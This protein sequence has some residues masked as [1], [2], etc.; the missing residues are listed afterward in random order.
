MINICQNLKKGQELVKT[1]NSLLHPVC[2]TAVSPHSLA[3]LKFLY[4]R[5]TKNVTANHSSRVLSDFKR[6][7][8]RPN[9]YSPSF[10]L[11]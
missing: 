6:E 2:H 7:W 3:L 9:R 1:V 8:I 4:Q 11:T 10:I 5:K